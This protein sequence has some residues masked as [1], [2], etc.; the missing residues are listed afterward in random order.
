MH[1]VRVVKVAAHFKV[2][3]E[4]TARI[5]RIARWVLVGCWFCTMDDGCAAIEKLHEQGRTAMTAGI[6]QI[7]RGV[8][9]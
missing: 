9:I 4:A 8:R 2:R 3:N 6:K 7:N 1:E 5:G